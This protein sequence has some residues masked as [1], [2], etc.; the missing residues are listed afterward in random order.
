VIDFATAIAALGQAIKLA[1]DFRDVKKQLGEADLKLKV[2]DLTTALATVKTTLVDAQADAAEKDKTIERLKSLNKRV[3]DDLVVHKGYLYRKQPD[4][5][6]PAGN[7][8]CPVCYQKEGF[9]FET[10]MVW[11][12]GKPS[13][14]PNCKAKYAD[15]R[16][17]LN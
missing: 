3:A 11:E 7:F 14:C 15:V 12:P 9:L 16:T 13:Q 10:T 1:G 4:S 6:Q 2:A 5:Q 17:F 8:M